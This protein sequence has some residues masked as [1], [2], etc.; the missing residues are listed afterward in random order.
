[1]VRQLLLIALVAVGYWWLRRW[2]RSLAQRRQ[3][4]AE[5]PYEAMVR[6]AHCG[7]HVP[8]SKAIGNSREGYYCSEEH[9]HAPHAP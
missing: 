9:R 2:L 5:P 8:L 3:R 4:P 1:M 6:C 7:L